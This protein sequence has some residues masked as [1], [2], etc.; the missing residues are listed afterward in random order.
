MKQLNALG[1][2]RS[3][4]RNPRRLRGIRSGIL[5]NELNSGGPG[6]MITN[7]A[8]HEY[9]VGPSPVSIIY[10]VIIFYCCNYGISKKQYKK[11]LFH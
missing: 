5:S 4:Y 9:L 10:L 7:S 3:F 8:Y 2:R 1:A 11:F 6:D